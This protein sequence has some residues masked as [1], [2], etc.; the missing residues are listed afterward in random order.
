[1]DFGAGSG[2]VAVACVMAGAKE[3][4]A[5]DIDPDALLA[6]KANAKINQVEYRTHGDLFTFD[7]PLDVLRSEE[8]TSEL[9]SRPHLVCR[10][11]LA[12]KKSLRTNGFLAE[13]RL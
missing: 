1:M 11:P 12:K 10:L 7:E 13:E 6:C 9:Q 4:I 2:V 3:V 5:C 8:H